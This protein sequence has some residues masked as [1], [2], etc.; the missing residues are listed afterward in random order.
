MGDKIL[1]ITSEGVSLV[2]RYK[3]PKITGEREEPPNIDIYDRRTTQHRY[4]R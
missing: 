4:T 1:E 3:P 2:T